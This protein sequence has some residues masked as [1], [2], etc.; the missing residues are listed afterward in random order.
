MGQV[1]YTD[2]LL[3]KKA[4]LYKDAPLYRGALCV[5]VSVGL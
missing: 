4:L 5:M 1:R 3:L 2:N